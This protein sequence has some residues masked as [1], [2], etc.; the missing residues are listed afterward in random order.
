MGPHAAAGAAMTGNGLPDAAAKATE[1]AAPK[2]AE[3]ATPA[4]RRITT[5]PA[6]QPE[7]GRCAMV[8]PSLLPAGGI[9]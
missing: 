7:P 9:R 8:G 3:A 5:R 4:A 6:F 2:A 1:T